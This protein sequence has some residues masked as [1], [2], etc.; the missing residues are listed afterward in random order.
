[1]VP[2]RQTS[3]TRDIAVEA[4]IMINQHMTDCTQFRITVQNT[5]AEFR[6]DLKKLNWRMAL[7]VG[8]ITIAGEIINL[9]FHRG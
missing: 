4:K 1:M 5:L 2:D 9:Y 6:E 8:G 3:D 7:I